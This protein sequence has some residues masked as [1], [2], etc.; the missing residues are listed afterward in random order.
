MIAFVIL[1]YLTYEDTCECVSSIDTYVGT[2]DYK[3]II[4]DNNSPND[5]YAKLKDKYE[6]NNKVVLIHNDSNLGFAKG[7]NVGYMYAKNNLNPDYIV[8]CNNDTCLLN[9]NFYGNVDKF[10]KQTNFA[11]MGPMI[12]NKDGDRTSNP[13]GSGHVFSKKE[14]AR[15]ILRFMKSYMLNR[16]NLYEDRGNKEIKS[17]EN[18]VKEDVILHG[19]FLVFSKK[20]IDEFDGLDER[21]F[22]YLEEDI[23]YLHINKH[24]LKSFF[25]PNIEIYHKEYSSTSKFAKNSREKNMFIAKNTINSLKVYSKILN[26]YKMK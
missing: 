10:Y 20:Y 1:H 14:V 5:S 11:V 25:C 26:E 24:K 18:N 2:K 15:L 6:K 17:V 8:M 9:D 3:I 16:F 19:S 12:I 7:N 21:T 4:V 13:Q 22:M 23:L